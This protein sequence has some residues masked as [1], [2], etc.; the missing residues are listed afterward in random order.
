MTDLESLILV[1]CAGLVALSLVATLLGRVVQLRRDRRHAEMAA[2][3]AERDL[4]ATCEGIVAD[5]RADVLGLPRPRKM[6]DRVRRELGGESRG[7]R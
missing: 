1:L 2:R 3:V 5:A 7:E 6:H 4:L